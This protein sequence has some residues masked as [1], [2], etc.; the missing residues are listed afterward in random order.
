ME[1]L[2]KLVEAVEKAERAVNRMNNTMLLWLSINRAILAIFA[3]IF[4]AWAAFRLA[5]FLMG[6]KL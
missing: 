6:V 2:T 4:V 3:V 1:E 5:L